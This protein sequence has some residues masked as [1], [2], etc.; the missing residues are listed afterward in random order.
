MKSVQK[1]TDLCCRLA[2]IDQQRDQI[3]VLQS[4][5]RNRWKFSFAGGA[6]GGKEV[7][8]HRVT[9]IVGEGGVH[10]GRRA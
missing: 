5:A 6:P 10:S 9:A 1:G 4:R 3:W 8:Q 7:K 2:F